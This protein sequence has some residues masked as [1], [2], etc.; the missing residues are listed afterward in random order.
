MGS[1]SDG[2]AQMDASNLAT[3]LYQITTSQPFLQNKAGQDAEWQAYR[4]AVNANQTAEMTAG[5]LLNLSQVQDIDLANN[6]LGFWDDV[7]YVTANGTGHPFTPLDYLNYKLPGPV[8]AVQA[9]SLTSR[10]AVPAVESAPQAP[11]PFMPMPRTPADIFA[12]CSKKHIIC[13]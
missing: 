10:A 7:N 1:K 13:A 11:F 3:A 9:I 5:P 6:L 4:T 8:Q 2:R 12:D